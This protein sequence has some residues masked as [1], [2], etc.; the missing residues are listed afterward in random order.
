MTP[1][2][3][4]YVEKA[5]NSAIVP[6]LMEYIRIPCLSPA[7]DAEWAANGHL[8]RAVTLML[9]WVRQALRRIPQASAEVVRLPGRTPVIVVEIPGSGDEDILVYGHLDKQPGMTGWTGKRSAW[10]PT[11][12]DDR[13]YGRGGADDGY[14]LFGAV[15]A[16]LALCE[17]GLE[18]ARVTILIEACEE[19]GSGDLSHYLEHLAA[20]LGE[21]SIVIALDAGSPSYDQLWLTTSLRGQV[22]GTLS[23]RVLSEGVHSGDAAGVV[24]ASFRIAR[25]LLSRIEDADTGVIIDDFHA[26][27]PAGRREQALA[28]AAALGDEFSRQ[29]PFANG[30]TAVSNDASELI[31]NRAWRPQL[32]VTG[33]DGLPATANAPAVMQPATVLKLSLRLPPTLDP[34][35]AAVRL[36]EILE[37]DPPYRC[38]A[39]FRIDMVSSGWCSPDLQPWLARLLENASLATFGAPMAMIGGGGGIPFLAL[40]GA[41]FPATQFVVIGVLGPQSNAHG[42]N[43]FLHLPT[44]KRITTVV[45]HIA[46]VACR[47]RG[48]TQ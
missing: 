20:R 45:A 42:P 37:S 17:N 22:A 9:D 40:L 41:R 16:V 24:P 7:F 6:A 4:E 47:H 2:V 10:Q 32:T 29:L 33:M 5:W 14:A 28:A 1:T 8:E 36:K 27:I 31:L 18:H 30:T 19:S 46:H 25:R 35:A 43:E 13:L 38:D 26:S 44:A 12:E 23:V 11:L 34:D 48:S 39:V 15:T 3:E 21:P